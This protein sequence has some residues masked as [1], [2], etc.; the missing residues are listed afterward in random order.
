MRIMELWPELAPLS[1]FLISEK[2]RLW[3]NKALAFAVNA[4]YT[5]HTLLIINGVCHGLQT[6]C[7]DICKEK[8]DNISL[9]RFSHDLNEI[10]ALYIMAFGNY[11]THF[12]RD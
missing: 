2:N 4:N 1:F 12:P 3:I 8:L 7:Q 5:T 9:K 11:S 6:I 10:V